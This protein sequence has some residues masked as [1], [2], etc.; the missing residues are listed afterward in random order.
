MQHSSMRRSNMGGTGRRVCAYVDRWD[1]GK[2]IPYNE[3]TGTKTEDG[4]VWDDPNFDPDYDNEFYT[5]HIVD[6]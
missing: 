2:A 4:I 1:F 3:Y 6:D 5:C